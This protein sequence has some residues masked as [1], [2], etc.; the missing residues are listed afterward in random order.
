MIRDI[1]PAFRPPKTNLTLWRYMDL[2]KLLSLLESQT[3]YFSRTDQF[4]DPYEGRLSKGLVEMLRRMDPQPPGQPGMVDQFIESM[5]FH[6]RSMFISCWCSKEH[7][8]AAMWKLYL[9][10]PEGIAIRTDHQSLANAMQPSP[11]SI[12]TTL[13]QYADYE[14]ASMPFGNIFFPF[15]FKRASFSHEEELRAIIW[16]L[17]D[18][19]RSLITEDSKHVSVPINPSQLIKAIHVSPWAP[20]WFGELV[21]S[22]ARRYSLNCEVVN[23]SLYDRPTY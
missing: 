16:G 21:S 22:L 6:R 15:V 23:S 3:L 19:N 8:S 7:E 13:V 11:L 2:A 20:K 1:H 14:E 17:E 4:D 9:Q 18:V 5:E 12:G 10:S